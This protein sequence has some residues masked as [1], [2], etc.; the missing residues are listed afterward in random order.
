[1][2]ISRCM[3]SCMSGEVCV[4]AASARFF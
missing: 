2:S 4:A 3:K 1:L